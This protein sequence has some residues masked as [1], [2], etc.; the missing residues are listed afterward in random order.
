MK[1]LG[2]FFALLVTAAAQTN[3]PPVTYSMTPTGPVVTNHAKVGIVALAG[4]VTIQ[5]ADKSTLTIAPV[6][7]SYFKQNGIMPGESHPV[8]LPDDK[9]PVAVTASS[10]TFVQFEDG[11]QWGDASDAFAQ[12]VTSQRA[13]VIALHQSLLATGTDADFLAI[14]NQHPKPYV[15]KVEIAKAIILQTANQSGVSTARQMVKDR[16]GYA[17]VR[18]SKGI[19]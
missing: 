6:H 13:E 5:Y 2:L 16:L 19:N 10:I 14:L 18:Q 15:T 4:S 3:A 9:I 17:L 12:K 1:L 11:T 8:P 7:D